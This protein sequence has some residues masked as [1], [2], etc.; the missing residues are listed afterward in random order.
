MN[1]KRLTQIDL[2]SGIGGF[3]IAGGWAGFETIAFCENEPY[4]QQV[5]QVRFGGYVADTERMWELQQKGSQPEQRKRVG[6]VPIIP[7]I[8]NFD[9]TKFR[10]ATLLTAGVPCQP[11][12]VAGKRGGK[13][14]ARWLWPETLEAIRVVKPTWAILEN[15][16]GFLSLEG[17]LEFE[18]VC[19]KL[20]DIGY[21]VQPFII[22]ASGVNAPHQRKRAWI[23][24]NTGCE[25]GKREEI[26]RKYDRAVSGEGT[27]PLPQRPT[28]DGGIGDATDT[29]GPELN[30][31]QPA[32]GRGA[33]P[34]NDSWDIPWLEVATRFCRVDAGL[35]AWVYRHRVKRLKAL[36]NAIVP[37]VA[38][39][40]IRCIAEIER[41][42]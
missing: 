39:E 20:E 28:Q 33:G 27:T 36:G 14:D 3:S 4:C 2:F 22:P 19:L 40:I 13:A 26:R 9:G 41:S 12:S 25:H 32:W 1:E 7:D 30:W 10:G 35:P 29:K 11:A 24:A 31:R 5:L 42:T 18:Q 6:H 23:I 16:C 8:R 15:V 38:F 17:G 37:Q 21:E 34:S